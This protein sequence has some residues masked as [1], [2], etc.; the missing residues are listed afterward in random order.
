MFRMV[1]QVICPACGAEVESKKWFCPKCDGPLHAGDDIVPAGTAD[2]GTPEDKTERAP[3]VVAAD[4]PVHGRGEEAGGAVEDKGSLFRGQFR[5]QL[6]VRII[7]AVLIITVLIGAI[8]LISSIRW[9]RG[10]TEIESP[11]SEKKEHCIDIYPGPGGKDVPGLRPL[12]RAV[13]ENL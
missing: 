12:A 9:G 5:R 2:A 10:A 4:E 6:L 7:I 8:L 1:T 3:G 11:A 13:R